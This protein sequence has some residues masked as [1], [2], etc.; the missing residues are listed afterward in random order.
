MT[1]GSLPSSGS[2]DSLGFPWKP[3]LPALRLCTPQSVRLEAHSLHR[4]SMSVLVFKALVW[5]L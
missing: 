2:A 1:V 4:G 3:S 5:L